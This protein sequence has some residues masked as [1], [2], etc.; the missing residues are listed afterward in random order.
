MSRHA[1]Y[2]CNTKTSS[3]PAITE[4][5]KDGSGFQIKLLFLL[6]RANTLVWEANAQQYSFEVNKSTVKTS[7]SQEQN[8][9]GLINRSAV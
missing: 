5:H 9:T 8:V 7:G 1:V 4:F 6:V 3:F 2:F